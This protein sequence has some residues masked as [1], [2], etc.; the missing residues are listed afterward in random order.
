MTS[1]Y[2]TSASRLPRW[3]TA[4]DRQNRPRHDRLEGK[5]HERAEKQRRCEQRHDAAPDPRQPGCRKD[6]SVRAPWFRPCCRG[7]AHRPH[8]TVGLSG[9]GLIWAG[10]WKWH[11]SRRPP[12]LALSDSRTLQGSLVPALAGRS[13]TYIARQLFDLQ[14][15]V[16]QGAM[17]GFMRP[18][19]ADLS[20]VDMLNIAAYVATLTPPP[21]PPVSPM[22]TASR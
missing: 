12:F 21:L 15:G 3:R 1:G 9:G 19:L 14:V 5:H 17:S 20:P 6:C 16:R 10:R 7:G 13:P 8:T 4:E 11:R 2:G 18:V 22:Q